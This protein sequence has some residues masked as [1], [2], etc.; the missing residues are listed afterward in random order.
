MDK[1]VQQISSRLSLRDPQ[2]DSLEILAEVLEYFGLS[3]NNSNDELVT[4]LEAVKNNFP[5]VEDF[6]RDFPSICFA[7]ATGV[8][9]TR[10]MGAFITY[11]HLAK[12]VKNFFVLAPNITIYEKL[13]SDF[14][15]NTKKYVFKGI[16]Q[17]ANNPPFIVTGDN[18]D[19]SGLFLLNDELVKINIFN[20]S[21]INTEMRGGKSPKIK[22]LSEYIGESYFEYLASLPDLVLLMDESHRYR[23]SAGVKALNDLNP[24]LGLELTATPQIEKGKTSIPFKNVIY[25]YPLY[26]A[27]EDGY[28]KEPTVATR[29]NFDIDNYSEKELE[30]IK[31]EDGILV[32]EETKVLLEVYA[33]EYNVQ[34][35]RPFILIVAQD[36]THAEE[37]LETIQS[38]EFFEGRYKDKVITV[39]SKQ[40]GEEKDETIQELV[41]L[42]DPNSNTE[43]V[44]HVNKLKE[45]WDVTNLYT[46]IPLRAANSKTLVEQSIGRGLRLPYGKRTGVKSVDRLTIIAHDK[47]QEIVDEANNPESII[48]KGVIIGR[49]VAQTKKKLVTVDSNIK[50]DILST[51]L[52]NPTTVLDEKSQEKIDLKRNIA[53]TTIRTIERLNNLPNSGSLKSE[54]V[55]KAI[56]EKLKETYPVGQLELFEDESDKTLEDIVDTV[57]EQFVEKS[58]DIPRVIIQPKG[59]ITWG[60]ND[61]D[62]E[63]SDIYL[64]PVTQDILI[65]ELR[66]RNRETLHFEISLSDEQNLED[67]II[68]RLMDFDDISYD[69]HS[70]LLYKL[71]NQLIAH[72]RSYLKTDEKIRNVLVYNQQLL[73]NKIHNQMLDHYYEKVTEFDVIVRSDFEVYQS[74][75]YS[76]DLHEEIRDYR[77]PVVD[78]S[79]IRGMS[80][81]GFKRCLYPVQQFDAENERRF[82][83]ICEQD[84][85]VEKWFKPN[86][87]QI[88]IYYN[89]IN[90][91]IPDFIVETKYK[92]YICELKATNKMDDAEVVAKAIA[93]TEWCRH[94]TNHELK[95]N[96]K[97]WV[98]LL[99]PHTD[100]KEN[101]TL[102]GLESRYTYLIND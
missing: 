7:L 38:K 15:P 42:E 89:N 90:Q 25:S 71:V 91:Y 43:I 23:A 41:S 13:I 82:S 35:V 9:K 4:K 84:S 59:D 98:Y 55:K 61:F 74:N 21:K 1:Y 53:E 37:L 16:S 70:E 88:K 31:L 14:T 57:T 40:S 79:S 39:H 11:L 22:R 93:A 32:H 60:Y 101:M 102:S 52:G 67:Y 94:A 76:M 86:R 54:E 85:T 66:T 12:G 27:M 51:I 47:F 46:L 75:S 80:F 72:L 33:R 45:G 68:S 77:Q 49:D 62:L 56:V 10:L 5:S 65:Q 3:K 87:H 20:I 73:A 95:N 2:K 83:V 36:T 100:V 63:V 69:E 34:I 8:G 81:G 30:K 58:I 99:I 97:E 17:F 92:K 50:K 19:Q 18:Y 6:E 28:V 64:Q 48:R 78:R 96:G 44:I 24:V 26:K 29:E